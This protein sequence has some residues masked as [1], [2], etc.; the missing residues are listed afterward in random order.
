MKVYDMD[1]YNWV[2]A[3]SK[4]EAVEWFINRFNLN[5]K[6]MEKPNPVE[7][8]LDNDGV[9]IEKEFLDK[10]KFNYKGRKK[11]EWDGETGLTCPICI[12]VSYREALE[13][14]NSTEPFLID[15]IEF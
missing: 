11:E 4:K 14:Y 1:G 9:W 12:W 3:N 2:A 10:M 13:I 6:D 7:C 8:D 5:Y 15:S